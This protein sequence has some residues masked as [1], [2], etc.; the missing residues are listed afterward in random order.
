[1]AIPGRVASTVPLRICGLIGT[2]N[3][4]AGAGEKYLRVVGQTLCFG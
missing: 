2:R 1:M 4:S 3:F